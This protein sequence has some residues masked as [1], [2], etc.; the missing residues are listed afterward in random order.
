M[1]S[2][3]AR[4]V[5]KKFHACVPLKV[6]SSEVDPAEIRIIQKVVIKERD[7]V[8][9]FKSTRLPSSEIPSKY[10]SASLFFNLQLYNNLDC[11]GDIYCALGKLKKEEIEG[12]LLTLLRILQMHS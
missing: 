6:L 10:E 3:S 1:V 8:F 11:Y 4:K 9:F 7:V 2:V 12:V 5:K